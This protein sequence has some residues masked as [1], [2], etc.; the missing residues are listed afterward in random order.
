MNLTLS[1][2]RLSGTVTAPPSKSHLHRALI[3]AALSRTPTRLENAAL[4]DD[5]EATLG[6]LAALGARFVKDEAGLTVYPIETPPE[7]AVLECF[8]SGSTLRFLLPVCAALGV[9]AR[10]LCRGR[11]ASRPIAGLAEELSRHGITFSSDHEITGKLT[12]GTYEIG[13]DVT[14][15]Y[16]SG[17]LFA[18]PLLAEDSTVRLTSPLAS[19]PYAKLTEEVLSRFGADPARTKE[20]YRV[21][22]IGR[23]TSPG[24]FSVEGDWSA[25][26]TFLA[27]GIGVCGLS[28]AS[29][30]ADTA[31]LAVLRGMG[32]EVQDAP[33]GA[34]RVSPF[35]PRPFVYDASHT[36]DLVPTLAVLAAAADGISR[37][38]GISRLKYKES[39][40]VASVLAL[41]TSLGA[42]ARA[43][44][45]TLVIDSAGRLCGGRIDAFGDHRIAMAAALASHFSEDAI[46]LAGAECICK[47]YPAFRDDFRR[48]GGIITLCE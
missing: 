22:G 28:P 17:L 32:A 34:V 3:C 20:T 46:T 10:F 8:E 9:H 19:A 43:E 25:A 38:T 4:C 6:A 39:D 31:L 14:S 35:K 16:L 40:R 26:A 23:Y 2:V 42:R 7:E 33:D 29:V 11:L 30:Q 37:I 45:D 24:T 12:C 13:T 1:P 41:L 18:L 48:A 44:D 15:Q 21:R 47:S 27:A 5:T 36:P